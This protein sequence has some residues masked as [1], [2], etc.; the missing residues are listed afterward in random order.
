MKLL[1]AM[2]YWLGA[3]IMGLCFLPFILVAVIVGLGS[4]AIG[5]IRKFRLGLR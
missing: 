3:A 5:Q 2:A 1:N 4:Y